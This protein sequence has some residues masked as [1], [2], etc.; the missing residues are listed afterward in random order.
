MTS[1]FVLP[2]FGVGLSRPRKNEPEVHRQ[3]ELELARHILGVNE[4]VFRVRIAPL[5]FFLVHLGVKVPVTPFALDRLFFHP[6]IKFVIVES[7][8]AGLIDIFE[9][10]QQLED[11]VADTPDSIQK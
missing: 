3:V 7:F 9:S 10:A 1:V 11:M 8:L 2:I 5:D 6:I 4:L